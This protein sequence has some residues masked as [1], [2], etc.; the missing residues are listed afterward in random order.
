MRSS[1]LFRV[2]L[3]AS[4]SFLTSIAS[5]ADESCT[6]CGGKVVV[7]GDFAHHKV[8]PMVAIADAG[9]R[10]DAY[11]ED[12]NGPQFTVTVSNLPAGRYTIEIGAAETTLSAP[13][14][15]VFEVRAGEQVLAHDF[16]LVVAAGAPRKE[17]VLAALGQA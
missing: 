6:T 15:R 11:R 9:A 10:A 17:Q 5:G 16:D 14:E 12:V 1:A 3:W 13:V 4:L 7:T 8:A 2:G